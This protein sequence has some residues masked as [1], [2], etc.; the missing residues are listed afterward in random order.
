MEILEPFQGR[1]FDPACG[2][3]GMFV[4]ET[5]IRNAIKSREIA[6]RKVHR[7]YPSL[8]RASVMAFLR[9]RS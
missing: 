8:D 6:Q 9:D 2:S 7:L 5:L 1:V 3:G 4:T